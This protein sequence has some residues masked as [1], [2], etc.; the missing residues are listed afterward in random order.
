MSLKQE[1]ITLLY[2][3]NMRATVETVYINNGEC[4]H[5]VLPRKALYSNILCNAFTPTCC[6][7]EAIGL[8]LVRVW[9]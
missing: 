2:A 9:R 1:I 6:S 5:V 8:G 4:V 3:S 7:Y